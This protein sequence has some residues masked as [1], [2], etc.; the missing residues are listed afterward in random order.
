MIVLALKVY[1]VESEFLHESNEC[2]IH[3]LNKHIYLNHK[4]KRINFV[5]FFYLFFLSFFQI[6]V[7]EVEL[8]LF[9]ETGGD[10][11]TL[12]C[13]SSASSKTTLM[14]ETEWTGDLE[15]LFTLTQQDNP[16]HS[17]QISAHQQR[18]AHI[19]VLWERL[20]CK[21][22]SS[23]LTRPQVLKTED[24]SANLH[25]CQNHAVL[26]NHIGWERKDLRVNVSVGLQNSP[27]LHDI[28][29]WSFIG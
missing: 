10:T 9:I 12:G 7:S 20:L 23:P 8:F 1:N 3:I 13:S 4:S 27:R 25:R 5:S 6:K 17:L 15:I 21:E 28:F 26:M 14:L 18:Q 2:V 19:M 29:S 22:V 11:E 24:N 16:N